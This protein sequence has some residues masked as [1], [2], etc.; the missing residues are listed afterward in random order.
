[1]VMLFFSA[2]A[3][4]PSGMGTTTGQGSSP[5][6]M[7]RYSVDGGNT[8]EPEEM[9]LLGAL[10]QYD[11]RVSTNNLGTARNWVI[12]FSVSDPVD[13]IVVQALARGSFGSW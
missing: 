5:V 2:V 13:V 8:F 9:L 11:T 1:M 6:M 4:I 7:V 12:D 3:V 10:G